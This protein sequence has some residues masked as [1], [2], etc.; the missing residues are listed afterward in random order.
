MRRKSP[1]EASLGEA[2]SAIDVKQVCVRLAFSYTRA[3]CPR[4]LTGARYRAANASSAMKIDP[5]STALLVMDYQ[6]GILGMIENSDA[7]VERA[8]HAIETVRECGGH[9]GYVRVALTPDELAAVPETNKGFAAAKA[10]GRAPA[11]DGPESAID[12]RIAPREGDIVVRKR[13]VGAFSTT[14]L[15][16][17]LHGRDIDTLI[18]AGVSTSGVV[19]STLRDAADRDYRIFVIAD[20]CAD[21]NATVH[22]VL[23][24]DVIPR[25]ADVISTAEVASLFS[26]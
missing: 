26:G 18:L 8:R 10:S 22:E 7:L 4:E 21:P 2:P 13:R 14:D 9:I 6:R 3:N 1:T 5:R 11:H 24:Q 19:L 16:E 17:Q 20:A 23:M 25:Q 15:R 12:E